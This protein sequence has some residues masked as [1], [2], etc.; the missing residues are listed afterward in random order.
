MK[1]Q[2]STQI[3][4][5][6]IED[7]GFDLRTDYSGR[8]M[9]GAECI[10]FTFEGESMNATADLMAATQGDLDRV[11]ELADALRGAKLDSMGRGSIMYFPSY[12]TAP[13]Y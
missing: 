13:T 1:D 7:A 10:G 6:I 8:G 5:D 9:F 11:Q 4:S 2:E 3:L 12:E